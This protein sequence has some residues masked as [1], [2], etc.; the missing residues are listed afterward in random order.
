MHRVVNPTVISGLSGSYTRQVPLG[1]HS[2]PS[3]P[4]PFSGVNFRDRNGAIDLQE[5]DRVLGVV[6][7]KTPA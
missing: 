2:V 1:C 3:S 4:P 7:E 6:R 5:T